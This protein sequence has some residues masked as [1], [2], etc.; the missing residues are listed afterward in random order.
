MVY[1]H[2]SAV[3]RYFLLRSFA[4]STPVSP[5]SSVPHGSLTSPLLSRTVPAV[6]SSAAS[7]RH[8]MYDD[9][10]HGW[11]CLRTGSRMPFPC[12]RKKRD[13]IQG[14][15]FSRSGRIFRILPKYCA[16]QANPTNS[17]C[18]YIPLFPLELTTENSSQRAV[19]EQVKISGRIKILY[20]WLQDELV[21][22]SKEP[23]IADMHGD[24]FLSLDGKMPVFVPLTLR[25]TPAV[26]PS[27]RKFF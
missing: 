5:Q 23:G 2:F 21:K 7:R 14:D 26:C 12:E 4:S 10:R 6:L 9:S 18:S 13:T 27:S 19:R 15:K 11:R 22:S 24:K 17:Q 20:F 3:F 8:R 25:V 1:W 16:S